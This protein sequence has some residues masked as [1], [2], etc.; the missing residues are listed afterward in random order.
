LTHRSDLAFQCITTLLT[1]AF[2]E[3]WLVECEKTLLKIQSDWE[4]KEDNSNDP[5]EKTHIRQTKTRKM[6]RVNAAN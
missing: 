6:C 2:P 1:K 4:L 3:D 5:A